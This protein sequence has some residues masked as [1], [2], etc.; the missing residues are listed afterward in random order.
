MAKLLDHSFP[1]APQEYDPLTF[2]RILRDIEIALSKME[3]PL[4]I[5]GKD[6]SR[7]LTW[8]IN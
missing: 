3:F 4:E 2:Q 5:D 7:A 8:F 1:D 6:E